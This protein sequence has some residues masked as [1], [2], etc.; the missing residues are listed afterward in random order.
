MLI[1]IRVEIDHE[2][3]PAFRLRDSF[4][5]NLNERLLSPLDFARAFCI[6]TEIPLLYADQI[7]SMITTQ[8]E[9]HATIAEVDV[10]EPLPPSAFEGQKVEEIL[11]EVSHSSS[12]VIE[13]TSG[14]RE[15][16]KDLRVIVHVCS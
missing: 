3:E 13:E 14:D 1:P 15:L 12:P 16:A 6:D 4:L 2:T 11:E 9:E 10:I 7:A 8:C 5:W